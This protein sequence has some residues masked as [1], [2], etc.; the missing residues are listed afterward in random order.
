[1]KGLVAEWWERIETSQKF[2]ENAAAIRAYQDSLRPG[3]ITLVGLVAEGGQGMRTANN[4]RFLGYLDGAP[5]A[6]EVLAKREKW[7]E[8]WLAAQDI[9]AVFTGE[10]AKHGGDLA[11]PTKNGAAWEACVEPLR[12]RFSAERLGFSKSDL[13]RIVPKGLVADDSDFRFTWKQRKPELLA[14]WQSDPRLES[15]WQGGL[16]DSQHRKDVRKLEGAKHVSDAEFCVLCQELQ[17]W[18]P[19]ENARRKGLRQA[20]IPRAVLGLRSSEDYTD[21]ADAPRI[22]AIYNGLSGRGQFVPFRKGDPEGNRWVDNEPLYIDWS[23]ASVDWLSTSPEARWQGHRYFFTPGITWTAVANHVAMKAR[24]QEPCVFDVDSMRLTPRTVIFPPLAFLAL[25][26]SD[27]VSFIKMKFIKHTQKWGIGDPR[28]IPL[29]MP[30][31]AQAGQLEM[32]ATQ[33]MEAKRLTFTAGAVSH[34]LAANVRE[35]SRQLLDAGP[36]Y[37]RPSAQTT[38]LTTA[39]DCLHILELAVNWQAERLYGVEGLGPFDDF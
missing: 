9:R 13:Y 22:A 39:A 35:L 20:A 26:N 19:E 34:A 16:G 8:R 4:A 32:L 38:L 15:F 1:V 33:A 10:L 30:T 37:L 3:D 14:L 6:N 27:V 5:Q 11:K 23:R 17:A 25:L 18:L 36:T 2:S 28:Q 12:A 31:K 7:S 21:P 29:V 24:Y